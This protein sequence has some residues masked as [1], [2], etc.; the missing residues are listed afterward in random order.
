MFDQET[1]AV[2]RSVLDEVCD[3]VGKYESGIRTYVASALLA[4]ATDGPR[5][6]GE[7]RQ[8]G[9][10]ALKGVPTMWR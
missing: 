10:E 1:T 5:T 3:H 7:L 2:L 9:R 4:A 8:A 6:V